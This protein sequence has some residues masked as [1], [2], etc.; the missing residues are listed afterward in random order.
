[1]FWSKPL[2]KLKAALEKT[3]K[4]LTTG[5]SSLFKRGRKIDAEF[6]QELEE[7]LI[8]SD[9]G[10]PTT[11]HILDAL[12]QSYQSQEIQDEQQIIAF[13]KD[14]LKQLL[15]KDGN[16]IAYAPE[17]PTVILVVGVNGSGKT[18]SIAKLAAY[19]SAMGKKVLLAASDTFRAAAIEQLEKWAQRVKVDI[20]KQAM[21]SDPA[22]VAFDAAEAALT[23]KADVL[24]V[25]TAGRL[26]NQK[27]LM[28]ELTKIHRV[29]GKKIPGA[30]HEVM[31]VLDATTGQ[32]AILQAKA[33]KETVRVTGLFL[34][35]LDGTAKGGVV[36]AI[37]KEVNV[38]VKFI[39]IGEQYEDIEPFDAQRFVDALLN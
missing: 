21:G 33:F 20:I 11:Q 31:L 34:A 37:Q 30:P 7:K 3:R 4:V 8:M 39:G 10:V 25:D 14:T 17:P 28:Q 5:I 22:A 36:L 38:P 13:L 27:N 26:H 16:E 18:T 32:N 2:E 35:K 24:I 23:R 6:L 19:F 29:I 1:M 15:T 9:V 12:K